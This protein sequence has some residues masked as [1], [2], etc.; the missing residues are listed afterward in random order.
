MFVKSCVLIIRKPIQLFAFVGYYGVSHS[1]RSRAI[2]PGPRRKSRAFGNPPRKFFFVR[3]RETT[4][5]S[6]FSS[7]SSKKRHRRTHFNVV[8]SLVM[9][10]MVVYIVPIKRLQ[11]LMQTRKSLMKK[12]MHKY[13]FIL[14]LLFYILVGILRRKNWTIFGDDAILL[15][16]VLYNRNNS[17]KLLFI[18]RYIYSV[19]K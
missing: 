2:Y 12:Y 16:S 18:K 1:R 9:Y 19:T 8:G 15:T 3:A 4:G 6:T 7:T 17:F 10:E 5:S 13:Y 11:T 14:V